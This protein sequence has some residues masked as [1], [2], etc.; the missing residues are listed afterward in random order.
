MLLRSGKITDHSSKT[1]DD[2]DGYYDTLK[3]RCSIIYPLKT[4]KKYQMDLIREMLLSLDGGVTC[5]SANNILQIVL[6]APELIANYPKF[7]N[8]CIDR[9]TE[10]LE[11]IPYSSIIEAKYRKIYKEYFEW[12]KNRSDYNH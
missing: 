1:T 11:H 4:V 3:I 5:S 8:V 2:S 12:L 9:V 10:I 7:R 6:L